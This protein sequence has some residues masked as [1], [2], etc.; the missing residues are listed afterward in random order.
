MR[1]TQHQCINILMQKAGQVSLPH[2]WQSVSALRYFPHQR[3]K[4]GRGQTVRRMSGALARKAL[5][6]APAFDG[7][8]RSNNTN[9]AGLV[10][11]NAARLPGLITPMTGIFN[12]ALINGNADAVAVLHAITSILICLVSKKLTICQVNA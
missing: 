1:T 6:Y 9:M 3:H 12:L 10:A 2:A 7:T 5:V 11:F 8:F 4:L